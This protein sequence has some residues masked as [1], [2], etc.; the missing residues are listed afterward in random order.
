MPAAV[1]QPILIVVAGPNGAGK[2]SITEEILRHEWF[3]DCTYVNPDQIAQDRFGDWNSPS[4]IFKAV[5][6]AESV[7]ENCLRARQ[8]LAFETVFSSDE[9]L[10]FV[11][12][13]VDNGFSSASFLWEQTTPISTPPVL[14]NG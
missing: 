11:R 12:R 7:R 1:E 9:K 4:A 2:T 5:N 13:A 3:G 8:P 6:Y 14:Q 10:S